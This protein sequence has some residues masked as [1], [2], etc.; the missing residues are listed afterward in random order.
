M[1]E[2]FQFQNFAPIRMPQNFH[3]PYWYVFAPHG[4]LFTPTQGLF[5]LTV[6]C[7]PPTQRLFTP[8]QRLF[9]LPLLTLDLHLFA[10]IEEQ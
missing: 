5:T 3:F 9:T 1:P 8:H 10:S 2:L 4:R 7:L 6:A